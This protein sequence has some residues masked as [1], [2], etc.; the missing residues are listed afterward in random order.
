MSAIALSGSDVTYDFG[1]GAVV[2]GSFTG[3]TDGSIRY[4]DGTGTWRHT[5]GRDAVG[6]DDPIER[7]E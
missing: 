4:P 7:Q 2:I 6:R 1:A 3:G 5:R